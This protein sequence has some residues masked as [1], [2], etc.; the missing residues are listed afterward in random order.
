MEYAVPTKFTI[1]PYGTIL[2]VQGD[3]HTD[4]AGNEVVEYRKFIQ[5]SETSVTD[6]S[7]MDWVELGDFLAIALEQKLLDPHFLEETLKLY[8]KN[9]TRTQV[10][11]S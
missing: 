4:Y 8:S 11:R 7:V 2:T 6:T 5:T 1:R 10:S 3:T 9:N